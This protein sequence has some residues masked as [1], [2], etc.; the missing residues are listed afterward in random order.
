MAFLYITVGRATSNTGAQALVGPILGQQKIA[1]TGA[2]TP[3]SAFHGSA[4]LVRVHVD[5]DGACSIA[6]GPG[7]VATTD[8]M[9]LAPNQTEYFGINDGDVISVI[10]NT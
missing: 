2:A 5:G 4:R 10:A 3:S 9:R 1:I 6:V 7:A 8:D